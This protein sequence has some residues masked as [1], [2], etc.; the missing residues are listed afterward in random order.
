M[1]ATRAQGNAHPVD[2]I[3]A[4][5]E[6]GLN[7]QDIASNFGLPLEQVSAVLAYASE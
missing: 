5:W 7:D 3:V 6:A 2:D 4:N 1:G